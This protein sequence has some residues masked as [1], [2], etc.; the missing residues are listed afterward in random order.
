MYRCIYTC[1]CT[2]HICKPAQVGGGDKA[3]QEDHPHG[4]DTMRW[5][6]GLGSSPASHAHIN[7]CA[8][9]YIYLY[10]VYMYTHTH[11]L[12]LSPFFS[13][14]PS[15]SLSPALSVQ[16]LSLCC[17]SNR[18]RGSGWGRG[19]LESP[20]HSGSLMRWLS[21]ISSSVLLAGASLRFRI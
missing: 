15:L 17:R 19:S 5:G 18:R 7:R 21:G 3:K 4:S 20:R 10:T 9:I 2:L 14:F 6:E 12:S 13:H 16:L 11:T 8:D 1:I